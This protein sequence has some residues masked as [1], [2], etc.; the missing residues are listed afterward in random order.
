MMPVDDARQWYAL[1]QVKG[2]GGKSLHALYNGAVRSQSSPDQIGQL[3]WPAFNRMFPTL[4]RRLFDAIREAG[5]AE[6]RPSFDDLSD[7]GIQIVHLGHPAYP[8]MLLQRLDKSAPPILYYKGYLPLLNGP[9]VAVVGSRRASEEGLTAAYKVGTEMAAQGR[10]VISGYAKGV[11]TQ[12]H[13]GAL[14]AE[15][16]TTIILSSGIY[17]FTRKREFSG[18]DL[19]RNALVVSQFHPNERWLARNAMTR[20]KLVCALS[21]AVVVIEAGAER[22]AQGRMSGT[23]DAGSAALAMGIPLLVLSPSAFARPP[24]GNVSLI[25]K[26]GI[27][28]RPTESLESLL[29]EHRATV[30]QVQPSL[31]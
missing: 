1:S 12:G 9:S 25:A 17:E 31:F 16:T 8:K 3:D 18:T 29:R 23:Y 20:N 11:D 7:S 5:E 21:E 15:G 13:L 4:P 14:R 24:I 19:N 27:E 30:A 26:G 2:L 28:F 22:D 6:L 10:N